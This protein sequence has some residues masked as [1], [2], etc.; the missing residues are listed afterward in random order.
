[1]IPYWRNEENNELDNETKTLVPRCLILKIYHTFLTVFWKV[2]LN[3]TSKNCQEYL[4][5]FS[6]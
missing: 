4:V 6:K 3:D 5:N 2:Q 1:M